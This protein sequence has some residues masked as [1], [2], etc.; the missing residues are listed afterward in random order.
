MMVLAN[1]QRIHKV[2]LHFRF[3][4]IDVGKVAQNGNSPNIL[5]TRCLRSYFVWNITPKLLKR[6]QITATQPSIQHQ[7]PPRTC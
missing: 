5:K 1:V 3:R 4:Y 7:I 6:I 2:E